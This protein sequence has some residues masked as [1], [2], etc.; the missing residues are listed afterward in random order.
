MKYGMLVEISTTEEYYERC[1]MNQ[2]H[3]N[4]KCVSQP[5]VIYG[6]WLL[7]SAQDDELLFSTFCI[8]ILIGVLQGFSASD[9][10]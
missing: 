1:F 2:L 7:W 5:F 8:C 10:V 6:K 4:F 3:F 9:S